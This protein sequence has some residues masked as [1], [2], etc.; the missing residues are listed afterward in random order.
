[1]LAAHEVPAGD[2]ADSVDLQ[3]D[4]DLAGEW[5]QGEVP[6]FVEW[7]VAIEVL[8]VA[9]EDVLPVCVE[10]EVVVG[11]V[12]QGGRVPL[13]GR[14]VVQE[15][16]FVIHNRPRAVGVYVRA[17]GNAQL[18]FAVRPVARP[19][20][21]GVQFRDRGPTVRQEHVELRGNVDRA[22]EACY[23]DVSRVFI[24]IRGGQPVLRLECGQVAV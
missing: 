3:P 4:L 15:Q 22:D 11:I 18:G 24:V 16:R 19:R 20:S 21:G 13:H 2:F 12:V 5:V 10:V 7:F 23:G 8:G 1:M 9:I 17:Q 14:D 6:E